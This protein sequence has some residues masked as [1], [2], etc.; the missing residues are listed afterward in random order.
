MKS[1]ECLNQSTVKLLN[2]NSLLLPLIKKE[3]L[4]E[5][6]ENFKLEEK[7]INKILARFFEEKK[8]SGEEEFKRLL[9]DKQINRDEFINTITYDIRIKNYAKQEYG[10]QA[11]SHFLKK[12]NDLDS[13]VYSL[14]RMKD[15]FKAKELFLRISEGEA[16]FGTIAQKFSEGSEK[17]TRGIVGPVKLTQAHPL[18]VEVLRTSKIGHVNEPISI[19]T[20]QIIVRVEAYQHSKFDEQMSIAMAT[21]IFEKELEKESKTILHGMISIN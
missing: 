5:K 4:K 18:L 14:I 7:E 9:D 17:I 10:H 3:L 15:P 6:I 11:E 13:V 8:I 19:D 1:L 2:K 16:D 12:K 21:D 20:W